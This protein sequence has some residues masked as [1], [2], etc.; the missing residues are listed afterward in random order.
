MS[1][2]MLTLAILGGLSVSNYESTSNLEVYDIKGNYT[3]DSA[4]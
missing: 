2:F 4:K 1:S 3:F